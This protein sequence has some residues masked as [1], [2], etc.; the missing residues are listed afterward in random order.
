[1]KYIVQITD[2]GPLSFRVGRE[3]ATVETLPYVPGTALLGG[4]ASVHAML[5]HD[6]VE[7]DA[8]FMS[9]EASFG[10]LYPASFKLDELQ[11]ETVPVYPLPRTA[12][13]CKR[14]KG[15]TFDEDDPKDDPHHGVLDALI[16]WAL[17]ALS[18]QTDS[19]P[20]SVLNECPHPQCDEPLDHLDGFY[21]RNPF[22]MQEMGTAK[23]PRG[24]RTRTGINRAT[25]TVR[26]GILYSREVLRAG[27]QFWGTL[28]VNDEQAKP[29]HQFIQQANASGL[30][31]LGNNRTRGFGRV[32]LNLDPMGSGDTPNLLQKRI[33]TFDDVLRQ[34]AQRFGIDTPHAAYVPLT[35]ISDAIL[36]DRLLRHRTTIAPDYLADV[37]GLTG[38]ELIYQ[39]SGVRRVLGWNDLFRLPKPDDVAIT[40]GSVFLLGFSEPLD[41][42]TLQTLLKMQDEGIG[43]RRREGFGRLL[44][45]HPFHWEV[46]GQ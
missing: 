18:G 8:F 9:S 29:F 19:Y 39:N 10:N 3:T 43:A 46:N 22:N 13:S 24:L 15:F 30:L 33:Q 21:R 1:M 44:V 38:V 35:L 40:M 2:C 42:G 34:Q 27:S 20:L 6:R 4:L 28:T 17:F 11:G 5:R 14:F 16:P 41:G 12:V 23:A 31:R 7:F 37:W 32:T 25:G 36:F 45:A 26:Q